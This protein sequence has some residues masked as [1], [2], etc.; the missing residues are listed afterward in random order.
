MQL[1]ETL[2]FPGKTWPLLDSPE[3]AGWSHEKLKV[4]RDYADSIHSAAVMIVQGGVVVKQWGDLT[5]KF[6]SYSI[7]KTMLSALYGIYVSEGKIDLNQTLEQLGIDDN[8]PSLT[9]T[10]KQARIADLLRARSGVYHTSL[11]EP[12]YMKE[13][14]P[15][16]GSHAPGTFWFYNN[17]DFNTLG[18]IFEQNA[19]LPINL[20]FEQRI[21]TSLQMEDYSAEDMKYIRGPESIHPAYPFH[22][23]SRDLARF[24]LL[25]LRHGLWRDQQ[26]VPASWVAKLSQP[27]ELLGQ[28]NGFQVG[29]Y[30]DLWWTET[31]GKHFPGVDLGGGSFSARGIGGHFVVVVPARNLVIVH[32]V[33]NGDDQREVVNVEQFA[34]LLKLVLDAQANP[35]SG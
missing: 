35:V 7:R 32:R 27:S 29:G 10:E 6:N 28:H 13:S 22:I 9:K 24:G 33:D 21:A 30:E 11:F 4:A 5:K 18:T 34:R 3:Q 19:G 1:V 25:Y 14:R 31:Q 17:W 23:S 2:R 8:P 16:R 20:A 12:V 15:A 26:I